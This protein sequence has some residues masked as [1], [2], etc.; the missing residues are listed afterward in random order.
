[1]PKLKKKVI[2]YR[3][4]DGRTYGR[5]DPNYRKALLLKIL[6]VL[7]IFEKLV[8]SFKVPSEHKASPFQTYGVK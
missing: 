2:R 7:F 4:T 1:M 3:R 8:F 5:T 6:I